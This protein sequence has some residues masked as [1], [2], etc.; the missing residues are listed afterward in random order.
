MEAPLCLHRETVRPEWIDYNG[1]MNVAYYV[2]IADHATDAF[3]D[4]IGVGR[5]YVAQQQKSI[6]ALD[7]RTTYVRELT[8]GTEVRVKTQL[9]AFDSKRLQY[10]HQLV[11]AAEGW[12]AACSEWVSIHVDLQTRRSAPFPHGAASRLA[13]VLEA[14]RALDRPAELQRPFGLDPAP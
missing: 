9:V 12:L 6:F 8:V 2:A 4:F 3:F 11:H 10:I 14:H 7:I 13:A 5:A 1:H